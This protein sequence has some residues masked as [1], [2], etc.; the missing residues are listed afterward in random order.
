MTEASTTA[1]M[2]AGGG[3]SAASRAGKS[4]ALLLQEDEQFLFDFG[5]GSATAMTLGRDPTSPASCAS[6][7][8]HEEEGDGADKPA[9]GD[10]YLSG[11]SNVV[12]EP[13]SAVEVQRGFH[14]ALRA[15]SNV[16]LKLSLDEAVA[17]FQLGLQRYGEALGRQARQEKQRATATRKRH[18]SC[19][20]SSGNSKDNN[21]SNAKNTSSSAEGR[22][23]TR[24]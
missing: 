14:A 11:R 8:P 18:A 15:G 2:A 10:A 23:R 6:S 13:L 16:F 3:V 21:T 5:G 1:E 4:G 7:H 9:S 17:K 24:Q 19:G 22:I 12:V 20:G